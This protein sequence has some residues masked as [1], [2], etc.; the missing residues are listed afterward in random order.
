[1]NTTARRLLI[2]ALAAGSAAASAVHAQAVVTPG[3]AGVV[4]AGTPVEMVKDGFGGSEGPLPQED[5]GLLFTE[6]TAGRI[7]RVASDGS[8]SVWMENSG[9]AN[10]LA[11]TPNGEIVATLTAGKQ[12]IGV[13]A[14][15]AVTR[16]LVS[17]FQGAPF[18][19]PNDLVAGR[20]GQIYFSDPASPGPPGAVPKKSAVYQLTAAGEL[21]LIADDIERPN[22]VALSPD[23]RKLYVANTAGEW[24][25]A[26]DLD[27]EGKVTGRARFALLA[28]PAPVNAQATPRLAS[29]ADGLAVDRSGR[30]Y[31]ATTIGIQVF[32]RRGEALGTIALPRQPQNLAFAG[33]KRSALFVVGR[34][35]VF[36]IPMQARGPRRAGK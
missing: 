1:M 20:L 35:A 27:R 18:N 13:L 17:E 23:E 33:P 32:S 24:I 28:M 12:G 25:I 34:G 31:V 6:N 11:V 14:Q 9:G 15:G 8:V 19:R 4:A 22:G 30:L 3:I 26:F 10:A 16:M 29:G 2:A 21:L 7:T 36:R 5:G